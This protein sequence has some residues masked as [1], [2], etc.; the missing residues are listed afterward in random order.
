[1]GKA[2]K[3]KQ[4]EFAARQPD[5][6]SFFLKSK[7]IEAKKEAELASFN[8][9]NLIRGYEDRAIRPLNQFIPRTRSLNMETRSRELVRYAFNKYNP[10][11]FLYNVWAS[12][13]EAQNTYLFGLKEDFRHWYLTLVQGGSLYKECSMGLLTK[14]ETFYFSTCPYTFTIPQAVWYSVIRCIDETAPAAVARKI[15]STKLASNSID[16]FWKGV[17]RWFM[18]NNTSIRQMNDLL[19]YI[20]NRHRE[21]PEWY[22]KDQTLVGLQNAMQSWHRELY[23]M[24][25]M[26]IKY[27]KWDGIEVGDS[28]FERG[29]G[30]KK[31]H[32]H[33]HQIKTGKEL[34]EEGNKQH[35][36]V[37]SYG[38]QCASGK[39]SIWSMTQQDA[40]GSYMRALTIEVSS[41]KTI[42]QARGYANRLPKPDEMS[43]LRE[44]AAKAGFRIRI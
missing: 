16:D 1:M 28:K 30:K 18:L 33:F 20:T 4:E 14:R 42:V 17:A 35:H 22:I 2:T 29:L 3:R 5:F 39:C 31:V 6:N 10:P 23:R 13:K 40:F 41:D 34:A 26:S 37:S 24:R 38:S 43:M 36:C 44:W 12:D 27:T 11:A 7:E 8:P 25:S 32:Y 9:L 15:A 19:D 21:H